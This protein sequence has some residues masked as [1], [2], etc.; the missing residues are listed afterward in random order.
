MIGARS[1][2]DKRRVE[3]LALARERGVPVH[4]EDERAI[5]G[6][7]AGA[8]D[9]SDAEVEVARQDFDDLRMAG[10]EDGAAETDRP[11]QGRC[12]ARAQ[13]RRQRREPL[14]GEQF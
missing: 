11:A 8:V 2:S 14:L 6:L 3:R 9:G 1:T 7:H 13:P 12:K 5:H 4:A 10:D